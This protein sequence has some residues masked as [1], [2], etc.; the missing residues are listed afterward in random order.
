MSRSVDLLLTAGAPAIWGS[1]YFVVSEFLPHGHP[2]TLAALRAAPAGLL[3]LAVVRQWPSRLWLGRSLA[4]G[5]LN[6]ALFWSCLFVAA[7]RL[8]G[9]VA[10]TLGSVQALAVVV[11]ARLWLGTPVRAAALGAALAGALG[12]GLLVLGP[13]AALDP[14]GVAAGIGGAAAMAAG[15]V[16]SR[17][18]QPPVPP[19][20]FAA[21]QLAAGGLLLVPAA[22]LLEPPLPALDAGAVG[23]LVYLSL[24]GAA[25][26]YALWFRGLARIEPAAVSMLALTSPLTAVAIGW[27]MLGETLDGVQLLGAV[28]LLA[29]VWA[30]QRAARPAPAAPKA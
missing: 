19:L 14:V 25:L 2:M 1:T 11:L 3:L 17:R 15:T 22:W 12:V 6:F 20:T 13:E 16:L 24:I 21:W 28:V 18:W 7:E 26:T 8:P 30:G 23:G 5:A 29:S 4:L 10:A 27:A 9:G